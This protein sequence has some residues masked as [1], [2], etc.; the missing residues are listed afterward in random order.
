LPDLEVE[1]RGFLLRREDKIGDKKDGVKK[2]ANS[3]NVNKSKKK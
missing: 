2:N 1:M 3:K